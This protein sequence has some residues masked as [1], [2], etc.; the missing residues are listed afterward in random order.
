MPADIGQVAIVQ[1]CLPLSVMSSLLKAATQKCMEME[2]F[3][4]G[5]SEKKKKR[6]SSPCM[7]VVIML[8]II[9]VKNLF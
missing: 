2:D 6:S 4:L 7:V 9:K 5:L 3:A 8:V 1:F